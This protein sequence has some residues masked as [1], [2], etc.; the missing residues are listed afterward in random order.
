MAWE[1]SWEVRFPA[2]RIEE[3]LTALMVRDLVHGASFD[4]A[5]GDLTV[6]AV[7]FAGGDELDEVGYVL[8][9]TA[10]VEGVEDRERLQG[11]TGDL[12]EEAV[13]EASGLVA[14]RTGL[15][16]RPAAGVEMRT[17]PEDEERWDLVVPDWLAPDG[18]VVP[19]GFRPVAA[20]SGEPW[21]TDDLLREHGRIVVV[22]WEDRLHLF[23][24]PSPVEAAPGVQASSDG[25]GA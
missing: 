1:A 15:G 3:L 8:L 13:E 24:I 7:D 11:L 16:S 21:P 6:M 9:L 2:E 23:G 19:F 20:G 4:I 22:P 12:L 25:G 5:D 17:V 14:R 10:E 18:A